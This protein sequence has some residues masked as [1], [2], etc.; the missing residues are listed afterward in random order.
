[1]LFGSIIN[2]ILIIIGSFLGLLLRKGLPENLKS[3]I[4]QG[5]SLAV[6]LIGFQM[7]LKSENILVVIFSLGLGALIGEL[8]NIEDKLENI[9][10]WIEKRFSKN[11][12]DDFARAFVTSSLVYC[13][14]AMAIMG[15]LQSGLESSHETLIAKGMIDGITS[16]VFTS[17]L[18]IGVMFSAIPVFIYQGSI[19]L[20][21]GWLNQFLSPEI[22]L[23]MSSVGGLLIAA[24]GFN[25]L[26]MVKIRVGNLLPAIFLPILLIQIINLF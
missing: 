15:A 1:M 22:I 9:G 19:T 20:L 4:M 8:V 2:A 5:M 14:G 23:E 26:G 6:I 24:I 13:V 7:A 12:E 21:A 10:K 18:G 17:T 16:I 25:I 3:T 11:S